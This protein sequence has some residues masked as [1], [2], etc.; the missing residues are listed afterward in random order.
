MKVKV[1]YLFII[2]FILVLYLYFIGYRFNPKQAADSHAFLEK[3]SKA[4]SEVDVGWG[5]AYIYKTSDYY[6]TVMA[7]KSGFLWRAPV[8]INTKNIDDKNDS[9]KT[10][11]WMSYTNNEK[12][13]ATILVIE[14]QSEDIVFIEAGKEFERYKRNVV[15]GDLVTFVWNEALFQHDINP[16]AFS[17]EGRELYRYR[18][19]LGTNQF[20]EQDLKW[21]NIK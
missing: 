9:I 19:P 10:I 11:G 5:R 20:R 21:H 18:Y 2:C 3:G 12:E 8:S 4:I 14:N 17:K 16:I 15:K 6:L 7:I 1:C 13:K